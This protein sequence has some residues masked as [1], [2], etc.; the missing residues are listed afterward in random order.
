[1]KNSGLKKRKFFGSSVE[2]IAEIEAS[3]IFPS[4]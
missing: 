3:E 1:M 4:F 2:A